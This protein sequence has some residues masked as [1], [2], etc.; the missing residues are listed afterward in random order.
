MK[1]FKKDFDEV[2]KRALEGGIQHIITI[3][4]DMTSSRAALD[5][6]NHYEFISSTIG[7]HPHAADRVT[8]KLLSQIASLAQNENIVAWGE[9]GLDFFK[10]YSHIGS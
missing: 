7:F 6:A 1:D 9:I 3:G 10:K 4:I 5:L 2:L 8:R